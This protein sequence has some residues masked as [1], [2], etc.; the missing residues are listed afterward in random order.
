MRSFKAVIVLLALFSATALASG[1]I[2][3]TVD[4]STLQKSIDTLYSSGLVPT[5]FG[6]GDSNE[7]VRLDCLAPEV[8]FPR[9]DFGESLDPKLILGFVCSMKSNRYKF[10]IACPYKTRAA[11]PDSFWDPRSDKRECPMIEVSLAPAIETAADGTQ[12]I[13]FKS[14][15]IDRLVI[16]T[17]TFSPETATAAAPVIARLTS[18]MNAEFEQF[19]NPWFRNLAPFPVALRGWDWD[20]KSGAKKSQVR[21]KLDDLK[22][23]ATA[24]SLSIGGV[25][26]VVQP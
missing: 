19:G 6:D 24:R 9:A 25:L 20:F 2:S 10:S 5:H 14:L 15:K 7:S 17:D 12:N 1:K 26:Q 23:D 22:L 21:L 18:E 3:V 13:V 11:V 8:R 16:F 4:E